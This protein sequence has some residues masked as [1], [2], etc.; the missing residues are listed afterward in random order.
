MSNP[1]QALVQYFTTRFTRLSSFTHQYKLRQKIKKWRPLK[2]TALEHLPNEILLEIFSYLTLIDIHT[3]FYDLNTRLNQLI[4]FSCLRGF[5]IH[6]TKENNLYLKHILPHIP[7]CQIN[8][9]KLWHNSSY[10]QLLNEFPVNLCQVHTLVLRGLKNLSFYQCRQL[11]K[12]FQYLRTLTMIDFHT[13]EL[14]WL[15]DETWKTLIESDLPFLRH[16]DVR[17][18][19]IYHKQIYDDDKDNIIYSFT[20]R[21][22]RPTY[23]LYT[24]SLL[25]KNPILEICLTIDQVFPLR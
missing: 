14:D 8:T 15:D 23:R 24:G 18:C 10:E 3:S 4:I 6:T 20:S 12:H 22:A 5:I 7:S 1:A 16:L 11:L 21:Y 17:I 2:C 19:V 25:K 9:L 13:A